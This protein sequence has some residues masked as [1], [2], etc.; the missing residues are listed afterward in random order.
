MEKEPRWKEW[1]SLTDE[2]I[3]EIPF[4]L[5]IPSEQEIYAQKALRWFA[6]AIE[7]KSKELNT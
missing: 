5:F 2:Q 7:I 4:H 6:R 1:V 3:D